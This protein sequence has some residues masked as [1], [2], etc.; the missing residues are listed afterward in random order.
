MANT[1]KSKTLKRAL[2]EGGALLDNSSSYDNAYQLFKALAQGQK[3]KVCNGLMV[4]APTTPSTQATGTGAT[5]WRVDV[6]AGV[7]V[8]G[9]V[10]KEFAAEPD[11]V[12]HSATQY[13]GLAS[14][15]SAIATIVAK[16]DAAGAVTLVNVKGAAAV[17]ATGAVAPTDAEI[18]AA[19][20]AGLDWVK[21]CEC[22]LN[23]TAD[24]AVTQTQNNAK[25]DFGDLVSVE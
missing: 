25:A 24:T 13:T 11:R 1:D 21:V 8:V 4:A 12:I 10:K 20:G 6:A 22:T 5:A 19:V 18:Q 15:S 23:R 2:G 7:V 9:G 16:K 3:N 17:T 14:L